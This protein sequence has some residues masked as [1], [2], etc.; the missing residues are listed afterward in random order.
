M[1]FG[2]VTFK[3]ERFKLDFSRTQANCYSSA[4]FSIEMAFHSFKKIHA[5]FTLILPL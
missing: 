1:K 4:I 2:A 5:G 3:K